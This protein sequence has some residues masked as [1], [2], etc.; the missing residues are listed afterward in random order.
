MT[1][2]SSIVYNNPKLEA[3]QMQLYKER[4]CMW[5]TLLRKYY[6]MTEMNQHH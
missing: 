2:H 6:R 5:Y 3:T 1:L 4:K